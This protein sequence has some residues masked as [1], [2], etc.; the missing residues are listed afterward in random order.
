M[1]NNYDEILGNLQAK[2]HEKYGN[3]IYLNSEQLAIL[4]ENN[5]NIDDYKNCN[6][7][8]IALDTIVSTAAGDEAEEIE[9]IIGD[10]QTYLY[11]NTYN[12]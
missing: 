3:D 7:L 1:K 2:L 6:E 10:L 5:I 11:Y 9:E 4:R 8:L 12:K